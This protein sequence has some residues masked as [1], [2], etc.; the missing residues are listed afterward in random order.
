[1]RILRLLSILLSCIMLC[2]AGPAFPGQDPDGARPAPA[3]IAGAGAKAAADACADGWDDRYFLRG[4]TYPGFIAQVRAI[5]TAGDVTYLGGD[6][7]LAGSAVLPGSGSVAR[8]DAA[9]WSGLGD[10]VSG[11]AVKALLVKGTDLYAGGG[12]TTAGGLA[13]RGI[14]RWD[15]AAWQ[16][17]AGG[18]ANGEV[19]ALATDGTYVYAGGNFTTIGGVAAPYVARWDGAAWSALPGGPDGAVHALAWDG[20]SLY[21]GGRFNNAGGGAASNIARWD[22]AAWSPLAGG[23]TA[24][25]G[26]AWCYSLVADGGV[27][28]AGGS[29][30]RANGLSAFYVAQW[31]GSAWAAVGGGVN[32]AVLALAMSNGQLHAGGNFTLAEGV[33]RARVA[34][35]DGA[36]WQALGTGITANTYGTATVSALAGR[37]SGGQPEVLCGGAFT[38]AGGAGVLHVARWDGA[39]WGALDAG[40]APDNRVM[41]L[42]RGVNAAGDTLVYAGGYFRAAGGTAANYVAAWDETAG[43]WRA[44]GTGAGGT[45]RAVVADGT[46]LYVGGTF[47]TAGG[48]T[49]T[50][51]VARWNGTT[52]S[53]LGNGT[54]GTVECLALAPNGSGG[55]DV[56]VGGN[57]AN[58]HSTATYVYN[59]A[60]WDGAAWSAL[61]SGTNG[62]VEQVV[63]VANGSGG[64][65]IYIAGQFTTAGGVTVNRIARWD[66]VAWHGVGGGMAGD[67]LGYYTGTIDELIAVPDGSGGTHLYAGGFFTTAGGQPIVGLARWDGSAWSQVGGG[68]NGAVNAL[69]YRD[70]RLYVGGTFTTAGGQPA[71]NLA[72]WDGA[73]WSALDGGV[74]GAVDAILH[75][76]PVMHL[77]GLGSV[78]GC[79]PS[80]YLA[81]HEAATSAVGDAAALPRAVVTTAGNR[82]NPFNPRTAIAFTL[83]RDARATVEVFDARG[84][85]IAT[86]L[87]GDLAAGDHVV[88]FTPRD[89]PSGLYFCRVEAGGDTKVV[90]MTLL[91]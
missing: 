80:L 30:T 34:R 55:K 40:L 81:R 3:G 57:F 1:M 7:S 29:F 44:L 13:S 64:Y 6:F 18:T 15:G 61:G 66:G 82:P 39:A 85:R 2:A 23:L 78:A 68:V 74:N 41:S 45:V 53:K 67:G 76:G 37:V 72:V 33:S 56:Y 79:T 31:D 43:L 70:G 17:L 88:E 12:F 11:G 26:V 51:N 52:W 49:F 22:G 28:Y 47:S 62:A 9:G 59:I 75:V 87:D 65:D 50:N 27:L 25:S 21:A 71:Q 14:A 16:A 63:P 60:R 42:A 10:G 91:R 19:L 38:T 77:A 69:E 86:L 20:A 8:W 46:D 32:G 24:T 5:A 89:A 35:W 4:V 36:A 73:A 83:A 90:K 54:G 58:I 84:R 48:V